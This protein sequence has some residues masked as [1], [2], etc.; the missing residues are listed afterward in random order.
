MA[1]ANRKPGPTHHHRPRVIIP[2]RFSDTASALRYRAEVAARALIEA[3]YRAGG[4]PLLM[5]PHAPHGHADIDDVRD[6]LSIADA[7]LLPGGGDLDPSWSGQAPHASQYDVDLE[8]DAFDLAVAQIA[9][10]ADL[11]LLAI[12][13]GVQAVNVAL[14]GDTVQHLNETQHRHRIHDLKAHP[15]SLLSETTGT[16]LLTASC[17]HHQCI[18]E[19]GDG[20]HVVARAD[21]GVIEAVELPDHTA[22]FLGVQWHPEDT[23]A[24]DPAQSALFTALVTAVRLSETTNATTR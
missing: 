8:Q 14:G 20:L 17:Y 3:V 10:E 12:C 24:T 15:G 9:L 11:P 1:D 4:E 7:I 5:H 2:S 13:R 21:D 18:N 16:N 22:W 6:R 23:A 19:L